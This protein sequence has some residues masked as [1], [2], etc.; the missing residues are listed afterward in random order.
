MAL[1]NRFYLLTGDYGARSLLFCWVIIEVFPTGFPGNYQTLEFSIL[2]L[3][4]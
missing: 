1:A 4:S 2:I 3:C